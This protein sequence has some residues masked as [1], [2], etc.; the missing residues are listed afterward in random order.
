MEDKNSLATF[1]EFSRS[2]NDLFYMFHSEDSICYLKPMY[3]H[4][5]WGFWF[6]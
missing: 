1:P 3:S 6:C 2:N 5:I 4:T